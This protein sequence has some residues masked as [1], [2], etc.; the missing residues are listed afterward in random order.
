MD[1]PGA[2]ALSIRPATGAVT[3]RELIEAASSRAAAVTTVQDGMERDARFMGCFFM[4]R[5]SL[6]RRGAAVDRHSRQPW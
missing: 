1:V 2:A 4:C 6:L 5:W 3:E